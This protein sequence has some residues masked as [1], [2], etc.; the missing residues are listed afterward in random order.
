MRL[1]T[2]LCVLRGISR[3]GDELLAYTLAGKG[4]LI[5]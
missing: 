5:V 2:L 1:A 4:L 3:S